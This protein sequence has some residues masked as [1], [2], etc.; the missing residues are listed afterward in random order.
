[1]SIKKS[2][3]A[4]KPECKV[5]FKLEK[6]EVNSANRASLVGDFNEWDSKKT[7][8]KKLKTG[9]FSVTLNLQTEKEYQFKYVIDDSEWINE[10]EA[11]KYV[12][13]EF[14]GENSVLVV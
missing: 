6:D 1:M 14:E 8:M 12:A 7:P 3:L 11:D 4:S 2:Y 9:D 5:T 13:N 10:T